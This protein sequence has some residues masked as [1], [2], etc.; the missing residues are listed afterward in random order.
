M[1]IAMPFQLPELPFA[2]SALE[3]HMSA[4]TLDFHYGKHHKAYV[5]KTNEL[6]AGEQGLSGASLVEVVKNAKGQGNSKLF[7]NSAQ[8]WN[9]SFFWQ[10]L[11]PAE[12]QQPSGKLAKLI[13]DG[14]GNAEALLTKLQEEAV[15][16]FASGWAWLVLD[17][18]ALRITSLH[19][20]DTPIVHEGMVPL[21]T[22]DVWEH[23]Y[24]IDYR[25]ER[26]KFADAVLKNIVNWD[27]VAENL[28]GK[29]V[30]RADQQG[31]RVAEPIA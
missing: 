29:G 9:H 22:L 5:T 2:K 1:E 13:E 19:D 27:F 26:P 12:G 23:A 14:F 21:F 4:E 20:A 15:N 10:C 31:E 28:D 7:N 17:R 16:H 24:Y 25:N 8:L 6:I 11:A 30:S 3:P 18:G